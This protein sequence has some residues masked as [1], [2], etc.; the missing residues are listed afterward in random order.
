VEKNATAKGLFLMVSINAQAKA[1][2]MNLWIQ[3]NQF[4]SGA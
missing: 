3:L 4:M 1:L 2:E